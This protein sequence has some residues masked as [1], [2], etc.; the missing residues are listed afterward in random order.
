MSAPLG[1]GLTVCGLAGATLML[2]RYVQVGPARFRLI[3]AVSAALLGFIIVTGAA[4]RLSG[5]GLG[6]PNWPTCADGS[7]LPAS[8]HKA[9]I[10]FGN[11]VVTGI[12]IVAAA[13]GV[14][15]A[16][17]RRP[18]RADLVRLGVIVTALLFGNA[19]VGGAVVLFHLKT[20][21]VIAHFLL[22]IAS[23]TTG[24]VLFHRAGED[25]RG[26]DLWGRDR[27]TTVAPMVRLAGRVAPVLVFVGVVLGT[28]T[29]GS[30]PHS[31]DPAKTERLPFGI[32]AAARVHSIVMWLALASVVALAVTSRTG[33][34]GAAVRLRHTSVVPAPS[35]GGNLT[36]WS[37]A[38]TRVRKRVTWLMAALVVQGGVGYLQY[39]RKL[40]SGL[41][42]VHVLGA[43]IVWTLLIWVR[44]ALSQPPAEAA[45]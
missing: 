28:V 35:Q 34:S 5:S 41:V 16:L 18:Y 42:E 39:A 20:G 11:R 10:E 1:L 15:A 37:E 7:V 17:V 44:A 13:V 21:I 2:G 30:G 6:C 36:T 40:P 8:S 4:V 22:A 32:E 26:G 43:T 19:L 45:V 31:G 33:G 24:L 12:C 27:V 14:L 23:L 38:H 9:Q 3:V 29:T 25:G